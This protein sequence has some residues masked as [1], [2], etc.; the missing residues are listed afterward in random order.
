MRVRECGMIETYDDG[1]KTY[2]LCACERE[3]VLIFA[4][5]KSDTPALRIAYCLLVA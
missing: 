5:T 1:K 2:T 3:R 4:D